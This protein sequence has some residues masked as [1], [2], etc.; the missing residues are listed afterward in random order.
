MTTVRSLA[1][2]TAAQLTGDETLLVTDVS[3]DSRRAGEGALFAAF[4][5]ALFD[6]HKFVPQVMAQGAIGVLSE[7]PAPPDFN[8]AWLQVR[9]IR[10]AMALAAAEVQRHPSRELQLAGI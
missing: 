1:Q 7:Q 10:R 4:S 3:H 8:G 6:A 5:G 9:N 2:I